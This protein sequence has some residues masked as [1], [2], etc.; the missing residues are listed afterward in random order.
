MHIARANFI[1]V[2]NMKLDRKWSDQDLYDYFSLTEE[3]IEIIEKTMRPMENE[4][5]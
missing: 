1:F 5:E 4:T 3:E 2:P